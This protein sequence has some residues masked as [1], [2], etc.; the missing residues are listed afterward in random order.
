MGAIYK[1]KG[2]WYVDLRVN[3]Q[4]VRKKAGKSKNLAELLLKDLE[5]KTQRNQTGS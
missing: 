3:G 2:I 1:R 5:I 4:R